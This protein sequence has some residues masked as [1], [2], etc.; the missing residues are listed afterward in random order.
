MRPAAAAARSVTAADYPNTCTTVADCVAVYE[1][2]LGCCGQGCANATIRQDAL[3]QYM[4]DV[5]RREP[6]CVPI[7]PCI[8][9]P[10]CP[11][12]RITCENGTCGLAPATAQPN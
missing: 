1:G 10:Q 2:Q 8:A 5:G 6:I 4:A 9:P 11:D 3:A 12:R 7:P